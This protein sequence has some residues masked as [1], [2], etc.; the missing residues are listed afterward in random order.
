MKY[1]GL[2]FDTAEIN[3]EFRIKISGTRDGKK[4]NKLVGVSGLLEIVGAEL[5]NKIIDKA[6]NTMDDK[7]ERKLRTGLK[8]TFYV[9]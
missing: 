5:A 3:S 1:A 2:N 9:K 8:I 6:I 7:S 4:Y